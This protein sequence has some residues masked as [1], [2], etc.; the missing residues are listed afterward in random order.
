MLSKSNCLF[1]SY[2]GLSDPL[3]QSQILPYVLNLSNHT[4]EFHIIS[5]E[6]NKRL[7][8]LEK[9]IENEL[10][11]K[12]IKWHRQSFTSKFGKLGK[13][14]DLIKIFI[15]TFYVILKFDIKII[16]G[17]GLI[18]SFIGLFIKHEV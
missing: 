15:I 14:Y 3:G 6:K 16:H 5:F 7:L 2:D 10:I 9:K 12:T 17:R 18:P 8:K 1:I 4:K 11:N 13:L